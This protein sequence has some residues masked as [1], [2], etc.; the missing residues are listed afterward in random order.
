MMADQGQ[1][2]GQPRVAA[3]EPITS[4]QVQIFPL[5]GRDVTVQDYLKLDPLPSW[6]I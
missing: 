4:Q 5:V 1:V 6:E 3:I 2:G